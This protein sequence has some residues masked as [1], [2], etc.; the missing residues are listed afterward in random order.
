MGV[1]D[2]V[3]DSS[4]CQRR[5]IT[6]IRGLFCRPD[7]CEGVCKALVYP[8]EQC[9]WQH[10]IIEVRVESTDTTG[11]CKHDTR[12]SFLW[13]T[14]CLWHEFPNERRRRRFYFSILITTL[15][16]KKCNISNN[17]ILH[18]LLPLS[19]LLL[20]KS[21]ALPFSLPGPVLRLA[22]LPRGGLPGATVKPTLIQLSP[23]GVP[24]P[25]SS[26]HFGSR[27]SPVRK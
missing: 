22:V 25:F 4:F 18:Y 14:P 23:S 20:E 15:T 26:L 27:V 9:A 7:K 19:L 11:N 3:N 24:R 10:L 6:T 5:Q 16:L 13:T 21:S 17:F 12:H 2:E 1:W 8:R